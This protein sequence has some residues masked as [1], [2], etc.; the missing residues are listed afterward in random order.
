M[1]KE[2]KANREKA[3]LVLN[4]ELKLGQKDLKDIIKKEEISKIVAVDGG[5]EILRNF[6]IK[7]DLIIGDLD[8]LSS[9]NRE[10]YKS[11]GVQIEKHPV[12]KD[13]T[14]S[15]L[16]VDYC[17]KNGWKE[18][19]ITAALGGRID[20]E[21]ANINLLEY[22]SRKS[23]Q[24]KIVDQNLEISIIHTQKNFIDKND[25]RLSLIPQTD[26]V[27]GVSIAGCKYNLESKD[28]YRYKTRGIS[29]L[30]TEAEAVVSLKRGILIYILEKVN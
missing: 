3:L 23:L 16:A 17:K 21:L 9:Q 29:N 10:Y 19:V 4:G 15:E 20:Q 18:L 12:E 5:T 14:D 28:L 2:E 1:S 7:P 8:S 6:S 26:I 30:I 24:A 22:I 11:L 25:Y 27:E 13:Q